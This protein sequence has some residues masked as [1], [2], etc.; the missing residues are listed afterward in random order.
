MVASVLIS[1]S[2]LGETVVC[3]DEL[4]DERL[5]DK[6]GYSLLLLLLLVPFGDRLLLFWFSISVGD[7][8]EIGDLLSR[9]NSPSVFVS[10]VVKCPM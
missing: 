8:D 4:D 5:K 3:E 7:V 2:L 6:L 1:L 9:D 10:F